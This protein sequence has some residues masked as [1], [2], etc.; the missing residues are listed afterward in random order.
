MTKLESPSYNRE[1]LYEICSY[2]FAKMFARSYS[3]TSRHVYAGNEL[4]NYEPE[5][6]QRI[7]IRFSRNTFEPNFFASTNS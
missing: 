2:V 7:S 6:L 1:V 4:S 5:I 3:G